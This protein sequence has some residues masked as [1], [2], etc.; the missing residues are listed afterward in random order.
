MDSGVGQPEK[1][2]ESQPPGV[3]RAPN[4]DADTGANLRHPRDDIH[5]TDNIMVLKEPDWD[6]YSIT[7]QAAVKMLIESVQALS[8][9]TGHIPPTPPVSRPGT[10]KGK[11]SGLQTPPNT[12]LRSP[13]SPVSPISPDPNHAFPPFNMPS[14]EAH[15]DE[16]LPVVEVGAAE[17]ITVQHAAISRRFFL[18]SV[19]PFSLS[20]YLMRIHKYCPHSPGVY[21][22][23][24]TYI[25]RLCV[26]DM[27]VPATDK[28]IH[29]LTLAAIRVSSKVLEDNKWSQDRIAKVGGVSHK[30]L[31]SL[32]VNL[33]FLLDFALFVTPEELAKRM[34]S[35]QQVA[36]PGGHMK[37]RLSEGF[38]MKLKEEHVQEAQATAGA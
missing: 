34:W 14:P 16:P 32:E 12:T 9:L 35:L 33:C 25:H 23:A 7:A 6:I 22:A 38:A 13:M 8:E 30:E 10:P 3:P 21:L 37:R 2:G 15:R 4:P 28:T 18:K 36:R 31:K 19:P 27:V 17:S 29:R 1:H 26:A 11:T 20:E 24:A 5:K